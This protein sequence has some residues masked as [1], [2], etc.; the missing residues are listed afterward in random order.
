ME[1]DP[2]VQK[3]EWGIP[4]EFLSGHGWHAY[5]LISDD[6]TVRF[7]FC[8]NVNGREVYGRG[9]LDAVRYLAER[10]KE[11]AGGRVYTMID[12]LKGG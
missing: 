3:S 10:I 6:R 12:V 9:T 11:G 4:E 7:D 8:H 5:S 2:A 1:R